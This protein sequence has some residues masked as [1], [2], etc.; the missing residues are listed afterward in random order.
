[1]GTGSSVPGAKETTSVS[2]ITRVSSVEEA[3]SSGHEFDTRL[4][5]SNFRDLFTLK[6]YWKV[7]RRNE[8]GCGKSLLAKFD[9]FLLYSFLTLSFISAL[10]SL[11]LTNIIGWNVNSIFQTKQIRIDL[12]RLPQ[13][14]TFF[15]ML[16]FPPLQ[17]STSFLY[18]FFASSI[19]SAYFS[20]SNSNY[21]A[22]WENIFINFTGIYVGSCKRYFFFW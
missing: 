3:K 11:K 7:V 22:I 5:Y 10:F 8:R 2:R 15:S 16:L 20:A 14:I 19:S 13:A 17:L 12:S 6:N 1:M 21:E 9:F 4:P 18:H